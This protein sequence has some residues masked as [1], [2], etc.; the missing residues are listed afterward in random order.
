MLNKIFFLIVVLIGGFAFLSLMAANQL[1]NMDLNTNA[2][3][4]GFSTAYSSVTNYETTQGIDEGSYAT[5]G[6]ETSNTVPG[7]SQ[8]F[9]TSSNLF[10]YITN[11]GAYSNTLGYVIGIPAIIISIFNIIFAILI[12]IGIFWLVYYI[13]TI[14]SSIIK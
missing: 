2:D 12:L 1:V 4:C 8:I 5:T 13:G 14:F 9:S 3:P 6:T 10:C 11:M 7:S